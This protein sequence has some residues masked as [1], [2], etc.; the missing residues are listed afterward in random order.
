MEAPP[1]YEDVNLLLRLYELRREAKMREAR[2][3]L[4]A[5]FKART[6]EEVAALCPPGSEQD[7]YLRMVVSYWEMVASFIT[8]GVLNRELF[9]QNGGE[10]LYVWERLRD[11]LPQIREQYK[12]PYY[13]KNIETVADAFAQWMNRRAP[14]SYEAFSARVRGA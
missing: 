5:N 10:L 3:W 4:A 8:S 9:F 6:L 11:V 1:T 7:A 13:A 12:S 2:K 14:G